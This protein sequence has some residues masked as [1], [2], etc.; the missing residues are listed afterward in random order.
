MQDM[1]G[2]MNEG[3]MRGMRGIEGMERIERMDEMDACTRGCSS[4]DKEPRAEHEEHEQEYRE[5]R[6]KEQSRA[7]FCRKKVYE[8]CNAS[9]YLQ[10]VTERAGE[11]KRTGRRG[12]V[13]SRLPNDPGGLGRV[14]RKKK[15]TPRSPAFI[16]SSRFAQ[17]MP[18]R[19]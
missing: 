4:P 6:A 2:V 9:V 17:D 14:V 11:L 10:V 7:S 5:H 12:W 1:G 8:C 13:E 16:A 19:I 15:R 18:E 3:W